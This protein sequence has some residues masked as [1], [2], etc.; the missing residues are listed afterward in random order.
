MLF[1]DR[2]D[3][4][5]Q[6]AAALS[7]QGRTEPANG[8]QGEDLVILGLPRGGVPVAAIV[9]EALDAPLDVII[10]RK[11]G[12]PY[13][14]ELGL[15][16]VGEEGV[17]VINE[18]LVRS[19]QVGREALAAVEKRERA[20]VDAR[21]GLFRGD[22][23]PVPL[24]GRTAVLVDDGIATGSTMVAACLIARARGAQRVVV[25]VPVGAEDGVG[26]ARKV[27]DE[28]VCLHQP[29]PFDGVGQWYRN[30]RQVSD[31]QVIDLLRQDQERERSRAVDPEAARGAGGEGSRGSGGERLQQAGREGLGEGL[32][33][34]ER[35]EEVTV[36][37]GM[38][39]LAGRL[40]VPAGAE[41][42]VV[43]A[44]GSGSSHT[45][46]RNL[47]VARVLN[48]A[49]LGTLL[50]DLLEPTEEW[51]RANVFDI[52]LLARRLHDATRWLREESAGISQ[53]GYFGASTG[54]AAALVAAADST[55]DIAA[56]VSRGG[57]PD[58]AGDRLALV[59]A[60]TLLIVGGN[61]QTVLEL[62]RSAQRRLRCASELAIVPGAT[63]LF[64]EPGTLQAAAE[65][66]RDWFL[67]HLRRTDAAAMSHPPYQH[68]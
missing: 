58:L 26:R 45:S 56:V 41:E 11:L 8:R 36:W 15:G 27:A 52:D 25:A 67:T 33:R 7:G 49:G 18:P 29:W 65:L 17:R 43:F 31:E 53:I 22:R 54:A 40:T 46:P 38:A 47:Y 14:P 30:F 44:H 32:H 34:R 57:R 55:A 39:R 12:A 20:A 24:S 51:D 6:L 1:V 5:R 59:R 48:H 66:A 4:G 28:V 35:D 50:F 23:P 61:D 62:N 10:V 64:E 63:H 3:A 60:P 37:A 42:I 9:A 16:A 19:A 13:Q 21:A 68:G 2:E